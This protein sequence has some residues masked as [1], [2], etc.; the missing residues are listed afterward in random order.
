MKWAY[1]N[2]WER[3]P[4]ERGELWREQNTRS[5]VMVWDILDGLPAFMREAD[6]IYCDPPWNAGNYR[7]FYTKAQMEPH[8]EY[9]DFVDALF[10]CIA[11]IGA[12]ACYLEVG[13][14]N[15]AL[16]C[17]R[18]HGIYVHVQRWEVVYYRKN[19]SF[20]LRGGQEPTAADF[21][22][23]DDM[24]TPAAAMQ[25]E[26]FECVADLCMGRGLTGLTAFRLGKRFVGTELNKRR[27]AVLIDDIT[28]RGGGFVKEATI[29]A[30]SVPFGTA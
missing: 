10:R 27:L 3:Y 17:E 1:G 12:R 26:A 19:P 9:P 18:L 20:L 29:Y 15:L 13:K 14:Q 24:D 21:A 28:K 30:R 5:A 2:A 23:L 7:A 8:G 11:E 6:L 22:G 25:A 16:F 4:I